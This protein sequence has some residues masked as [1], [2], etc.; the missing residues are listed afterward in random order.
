MRIF[1]NIIIAIKL[2]EKLKDEQLLLAVCFNNQSITT[3]K[4]K[5]D[6]ITGFSNEKS[7]LLSIIGILCDYFCILLRSTWVRIGKMNFFL[8]FVL[9]QIYSQ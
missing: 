8:I 5:V 6:L 1:S 7:Q 2:K 9:Y 3:M 4:K